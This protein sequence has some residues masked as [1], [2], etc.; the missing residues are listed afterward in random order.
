MTNDLLQPSPVA[1][2]GFSR[3]LLQPSPGFSRIVFGLLEKPLL[4]NYFG[5]LLQPG[6]AQK[7]AIFSSPGGLLH[8][9][10]SEHYGEARFSC[11]SAS[12][13]TGWLPSG[14]GRHRR[15]GEPTW[16]VS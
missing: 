16:K 11:F 14:E 15:G 7:S 13:P 2:P 10:F 4:H 9:C 5:P 8:N 1:S 6:E 3:T 12:P